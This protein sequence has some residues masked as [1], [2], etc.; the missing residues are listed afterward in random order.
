MTANK[1]IPVPLC[2]ISNSIVFSRCREDDSIGFSC[3]FDECKEAAE[4]P[5]P[6]ATLQFTVDSCCA[7][8]DVRGKE[9]IKKLSR[10]YVDGQEY[11]AGNLIYSQ[12]FPCYKCVCDDQ[13]DN[14]TD[15]AT[16]S[17]CKRIDCGI[18]L[19]QLGYVRNGAVPVYLSNGFCCPFEFRH[20]KLCSLSFICSAMTRIVRYFFLLLI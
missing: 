19:L 5:P 17:S 10:C 9:E 15:V 2:F 12:Q 4:Q 6:D 16:S 1:R 18:E 13:F 7:T 3:S 14:A 20:R 8:N 11:L